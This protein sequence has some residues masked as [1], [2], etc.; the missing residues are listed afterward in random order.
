VVN[1]EVNSNE[2]LRQTVRALSN[3]FIWVLFWL[4]FLVSGIL[5]H[6]WTNHKHPKMIGQT[7]KALRKRN[8]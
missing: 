7:M 3:R 1:Q 8:D 2:A 6:R 5:V 4:S